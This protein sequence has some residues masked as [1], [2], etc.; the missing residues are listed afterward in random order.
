MNPN[1]MDKMADESS[2]PMQFIS[3]GTNEDIQSKFNHYY[4][5]AIPSSYE[6]ISLMRKNQ[7]MPIDYSQFA[8]LDGQNIRYGSDL[9]ASDLLSATAK[10]AVHTIDT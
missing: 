5:I 10:A 7:L 9:L 1:I 8:S 2:I 4:D 3:Y 6:V